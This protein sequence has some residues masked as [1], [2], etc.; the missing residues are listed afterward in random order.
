MSKQI[1][2]TKGHLMD[3]LCPHTDGS[4]LE[5]DGVVYDCTLNQTE[6]GVNANKFYNIQIIQLQN[7]FVVY[8]RYGRI[9][10][11][12]TSTNDFFNTKQQAIS[13][14]K[15]K[16]KTK[17]GNN[18]GEPFA[19]KPKKY[20]FSEKDVVEQSIEESESDSSSNSEPEVEL[21]KRV[22]KFLELI[23]NV[24]YMKA[25]L[26][27]LEIDLEKMPL[28][29]I[30]QSQID[31]AYEILNQINSN[32]KNKTK[33]E[34]LSSEFYTLIPQVFG[35]KAPPIINN[36]DL[37][38]KNL[39][40]LNELS[41]MV[42]GAVSVTKLKGNK[43][44]PLLKLY[45]DLH[46]DI[47]P[48]DSTDKM[49]KLLDDYMKRSMAPTHNFKY[50]IVEIFQVDRHAERDLYETYS[51]KLKNHT[52]LFHGTS[53][54]NL[55]GIL[56]NGLV[57]DPSRLGINVNITGKMFGLG[58]YFANSCSKSIQYTNYRASDNLCCLFVTEVALGKMLSKTQS[59]SSLTASTLTKGYHSV[60]GRG[61]SSFAEYDLYDDNTQ[62]P[63]GKLAKMNSNQRHSLLYDEFI[64]Y[65]EE[66]INIRFVI[67]LKI[68]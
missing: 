32:M 60:W 41:Q 23:S 9:G 12:G 37:V 11:D 20:F 28:G 56:T 67:I 46:T 27:E 29:K 18:W 61:S 47:V 15:S 48:L 51:T 65:K 7:K 59:D 17:T 42:F 63:S 16:F 39:N 3:P 64:V 45:T 36:A 19:K 30:R 8:I 22:V 49:Y 53:I 58:L 26:V 1:V 43:S 13:H 68:K 54:S 52:L 25:T 50:D 10:N 44:N 2:S 24:V 33:L 4:I 6:I 38:G 57:V 21:D 31:S 14:F 34:T 40:L 62:I 66:Q 35:Y 55:I 5:S